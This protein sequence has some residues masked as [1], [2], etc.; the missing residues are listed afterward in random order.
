MRLIDADKVIQE[1][2]KFVVCKLGEIKASDIKKFIDS[3]PTINVLEENN[4]LKLEIERLNNLIK[5]MIEEHDMVPNLDECTTS[6]LKQE[7]KRRR[8]NDR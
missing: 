8:K 2:S 7:I 5:I 4:K 6:K 3:Q 1:L